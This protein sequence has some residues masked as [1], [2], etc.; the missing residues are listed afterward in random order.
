MGHY[1]PFKVA[2][3][4]MIAT[5]V[6]SILFA[7][8]S[9]I[10]T[11]RLT[12]VHVSDIKTIPTELGDLTGQLDEYG[13]HTR[14]DRSKFVQMLNA[15]NTMLG[16]PPRPASFD[17]MTKPAAGRFVLEWNFLGMPFGWT[18]E[19]PEYRDVIYVRNDWGW[20]YTPIKPQ[21]WEMINKANGRDVR[22]MTIHPFWAHI[23]GWLYVL[24]LLVT[25][26]LWNRG[27][28]LRREELGLID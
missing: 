8:R 1:T 25:W 26:G 11:R 18:S 17:H 6:G 12:I 13:V 23:W 27:N 24:G 15:A 14:D 9:I 7:E 3:A 19:A 28:V 16:H 21:A 20:L 10:L 4:V 5:L 2:A 22:A